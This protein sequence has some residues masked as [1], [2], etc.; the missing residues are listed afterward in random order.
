MTYTVQFIA[1]GE[2]QTEVELTPKQIKNITT[3]IRLTS[4]SNLK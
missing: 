3:L 1:N 4:G 2:L